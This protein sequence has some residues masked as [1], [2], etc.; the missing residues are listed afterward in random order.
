[1]QRPSSTQAP[2]TPTAGSAVPKSPSQARVTPPSPT[3]DRIWLTTPVDES[4]Q[5]HA[6]PAATSGT[7]CGRNSTV[8]AAALIRP[9]RDPPHHRRDD[10]AEHDRDAAE[11]DDQLERVPEDAEQVVVGEDR[12]EVGEPDPLRRARCRPTSRAST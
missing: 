10:Q 2:I 8:R 1:M 5:L 12:L 11:E 7:T 6:I 4:T 3:A 9:R